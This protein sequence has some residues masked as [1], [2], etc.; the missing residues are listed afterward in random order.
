MEGSFCCSIVSSEA[1]PLKLD[2]CQSISIFLSQLSALSQRLEKYFE[3]IEK[4][5]RIVDGNI[6]YQVDFTEK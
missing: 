6:V 5:M 2:S 1:L 3:L 4:E